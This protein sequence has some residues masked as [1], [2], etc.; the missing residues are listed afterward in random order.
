M[1]SARSKS[2]GTRGTSNSDARHPKRRLA[3]SDRNALSVFAACARAHAEVVAH[4]VDLPQ[5]VRPVTDEIRIAERLSDLSILNEIGLGHTKDE[6]ASCSVDLTATEMS[7]V[8]PAIGLG[9]DLVGILAASDL[10]SWPGESPTCT[11]SK[12]RSR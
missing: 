6:V 5:Y 7:D 11:R 3:T 2:S 10:L 4:C 9:D 12:C 8:D 1:R